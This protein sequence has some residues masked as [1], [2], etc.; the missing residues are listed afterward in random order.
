VRAFM[1]VKRAE[2]ERFNAEPTALDYAWYLRL[3]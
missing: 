2:C 3:A 1:A